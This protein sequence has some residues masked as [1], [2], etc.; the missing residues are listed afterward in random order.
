MFDNPFGFSNVNQQSGLN[1][2]PQ[3]NASYNAPRQPTASPLY[4]RIVTNI[5]EARASQIAL[6][7]SQWYFPSPAENKIYV[8]SIG[9][10]GMPVFLTYELQKD[11][12]CVKSE[13]DISGLVKRIER[14]EEVINNGHNAT[15]ADGVNATANQ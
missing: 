9:M 7:G 4:G 14:L 11:L 13:Q 3:Y 12:T 1:Y 2:Y 6:D 5:D 15:N 8:K 10:N